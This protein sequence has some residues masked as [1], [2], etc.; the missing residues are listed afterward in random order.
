MIV[1]PL[2]RR[3]GYASQA[4]ELMMDYSITLPSLGLSPKDFVVKVGK[5]NI[6]SIRMFEKMGFG[7]VKEVE[8]FGEVEMK[9]RDPMS[10]SGARANEILVQLSI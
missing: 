4:L 1:S 8:V 3:K 9:L 5:G 10:W 7:I 2:C 6:G